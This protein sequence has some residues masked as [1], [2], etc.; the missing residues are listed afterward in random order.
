MFGRPG[1]GKSFQIRT[2]LERRSV[3]TVSINAADLESDRAGTPGKLV[4]SVYED[5]GHRIEEGRPAAV[6]VDDFDTTVGEWENSTTTVNHQQ[7]LAQLMHLADS[8]TEAAGKKLRRVPVFITG[9]DL[10]KI[11]PPLRRPGRMRAF[12]WLLTQPERETIVAGILAGVLAADEVPALLARVP[13]APIAFFSDL[14]SEILARSSEAEVRRLA[15]D[16]PGLVRAGSRDQDAPALQMSKNPLSPAEIGDLAAGIWSDRGI[17]TRSH[18][19][20]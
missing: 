9:N 10:S 17:A 2:H 6:L 1:D 12:P 11:Y 18:L 4:L 7:V 8:P 19:G 13:D 15:Q 3:L 16:L 20:K 5:A 14:L